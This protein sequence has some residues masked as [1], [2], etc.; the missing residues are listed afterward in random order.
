MKKNQF[1]KRMVLSRETLRNLE[2]SDLGVAGGA[3]TVCTGGT[4][5]SDCHCTNAT[6]CT[7]LAC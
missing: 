2:A 7:S 4:A 3:T 5:I 6:T 1:Q